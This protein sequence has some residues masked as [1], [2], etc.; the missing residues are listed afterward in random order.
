VSSGIAPAPFVEL[1]HTGLERLV[2]M[3]ARI[4]AQHCVGQGRDE[5]PGWMVEE[6]ATGHEPRRPLHLTLAVEGLQQVSPQDF[7]V[8][9]QPLQAL[10]VIAGNR[11]R[12]MLR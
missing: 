9:W 8:G 4:L 5:G 7:E 11:R 3:K 10:A 2:G 1:A 12:G 6:E